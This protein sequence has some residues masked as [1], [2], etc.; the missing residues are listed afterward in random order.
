V[1]WALVAVNICLFVLLSWLSRL[2]MVGSVDQ[3]VA[4]DRVA[5]AASEA[6]VAL[7][8][9]EDTAGHA[10]ITIRMSFSLRRVRRGPYR[11]TTKAHTSVD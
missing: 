10:R 1:Q 2:A 4:I 3:K 8:R 9:L 11:I 6:L 7:T 5:Q